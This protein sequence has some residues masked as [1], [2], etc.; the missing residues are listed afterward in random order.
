LTG[1][2]PKLDF[3]FHEGVFL[4]LEHIEERW[5]CGYEPYTFVDIPRAEH[6][7]EAVQ[8][9][10]TNDAPDA[11]NIPFG[12]RGGDPAGD[13]RRDALGTEVQQTLGSNC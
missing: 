13:W 12:R 4:K 2:V 8:L 5:W 11:L 7:E 9:A 1:I 10:S 3:P 6:P